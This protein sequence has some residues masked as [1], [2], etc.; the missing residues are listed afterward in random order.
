M[1]FNLCTMK[2]R[3]LQ[4]SRILLAALLLLAAVYG[5]VCYEK[6][7][8]P[9]WLPVAFALGA[10]IAT[11]PLLARG[12]RRLTGTDDRTLNGL[13]HL[14]GAGAV[15]YFAFMGG[16]Y[17]LADPATEYG[18]RTAVVR[19]FR[20][21]RRRSYRSGHRRVPGKP[22]TVYY[23]EVAFADTARKTMQV[24]PAVYNACRENRS[25]EVTMRQG[26]WGYPVIVRFG[27][28]AAGATGT[29]S[30]TGPTGMDAAIDPAAAR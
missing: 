16:N 30:S 4:G 15:F 20:K 24:P 14:L 13:C 9:W 19:K 27:A 28:P 11:M 1:P 7:L 23:L 10:A 26:F 29:A 22:Y 17:L 12:M 21:E 6:T 5:Y 18:D 3:F 2:N 25:E 8:I